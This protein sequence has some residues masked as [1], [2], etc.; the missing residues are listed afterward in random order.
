MTDRSLIP[1][2]STLVTCS[3]ADFQAAITRALDLCRAR[4]G[5]LK[6]LD[7]KSVV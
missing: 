6:Q 7:R 5:D 3:A 2:A 4:I 1:D